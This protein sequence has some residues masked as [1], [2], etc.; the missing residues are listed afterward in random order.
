MLMLWRMLAHTHVM[1]R[2]VHC[3][4]RASALLVMLQAMQLLVPQRMSHLNPVI[5]MGAHPLAA[6]RW[7]QQASNG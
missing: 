4:R 3:F 7:C 6:K 5:I 2:S 1:W